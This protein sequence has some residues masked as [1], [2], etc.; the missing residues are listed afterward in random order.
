MAEAPVGE[1]A[2]KEEER[3]PHLPT[4]PLPEVG[5]LYGKEYWKQVLQLVLPPAVHTV[6]THSEF[7]HISQ[8]INNNSLILHITLYADVHTINYSLIV[9]L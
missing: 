8:I 2:P 1:D 7:M 4:I 6:S 3:Q 5:L 9:L